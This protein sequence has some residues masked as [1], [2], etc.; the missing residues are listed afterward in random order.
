MLKRYVCCFA[1]CLSISLIFLSCDD[2]DPDNEKPSLNLEIIRN[3]IV[4]DPQEPVRGTVTFKVNATDNLKI[5]H[6]QLLVDNQVVNGRTGSDLLELSFDTRTLSDGVHSIKA[7][8]SDEAGNTSENTFEVGIQNVL[9]RYA[10]PKN[11]NSNSWLVLSDNTGT[12]HDYRRNNNGET[13]TFLYPQEYTDQT[14]DLTTIAN[15]DRAYY[16]TVTQVPPGDYFFTNADETAVGVHTLNVPAPQDYTDLNYDLQNLT[17]NTTISDDKSK[18]EFS[19]SKPVSNLYLIVKKVSSGEERYY[20]NPSISAGGSTTL[21]ETLWNEMKPLTKHVVPSFTNSDFVVVFGILPDGRE[22]FCSVASSNGPSVSIGYPQE[23]LGPV[24]TAFVTSVMSY[25]GQGD[26][27]VT[28]GVGK[29]TVGFLPEIENFETN[30]ISLTKK[31]YPVLQLTTSGA[32][33]YATYRVGTK[34]G[35]LPSIA[36]DIHGPFSP[37][38]EVQF[39]VFTNEFLSV[40]GL[41][42]LPALDVKAINFYEYG[43]IDGYEPLVD[44]LMTGFPDGFFGDSLVKNFYPKEISGGRSISRQQMIEQKFNH[45][46]RKFVFPGVR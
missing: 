22:I 6:I 32:A 41:T 35:A 3:G 28:N 37:E 1:V 25:S 12:V 36:W 24:F 26:F 23:L 10:F 42:S 43:S 14:F 38:I 7:M 46:E 8:A 27:F 29:K 39:P 31:Q 34:D 44:N 11:Y 4:I 5:A 18:Y 15:G 21:D 2:E 20:Y 16:R 17:Y 30:L 19:L 33:D 45:R 40:I 9:Y 13:I